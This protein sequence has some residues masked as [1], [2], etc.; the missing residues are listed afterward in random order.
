MILF[1]HVLL[2]SDLTRQ[3]RLPKTLPYPPLH[4]ISTYR[5]CLLFFYYKIIIDFVPLQYILYPLFYAIIKLIPLFTIPKDE[6]T[7]PSPSPPPTT[8][9][10]ARPRSPVTEIII[11]TLR[12]ELDLVNI[13]YYPATHPQN[14]DITCS[15]STTVC[16]V[17]S[18]PVFDPRSVLD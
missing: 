4:I 8:P 5:N 6:R 14:K 13:K 12:S 1:L 16:S 7:T 10:S 9:S 11:M 15:N 3:R 17:R 18:A 2:S